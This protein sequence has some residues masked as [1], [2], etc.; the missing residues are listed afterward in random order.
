M[1]Q[2]FF[3][4]MEEDKQ[5]DR[6]VV[7]VLVTCG[8]TSDLVCVACKGIAEAVHNPALSLAM[9]GCIGV[10]S[11]V[12]AGLAL[13]QVAQLLEQKG[14]SE[15][16]LWCNGVRVLGIVGGV[17]CCA[18]S[19]GALLLVAAGASAI[20]VCGAGVARSLDLHRRYMQCH[21][22]L[23]ASTDAQIL[24]D[25]IWKNRAMM[26][27]EEALSLLD[28]FWQTQRDELLVP[29]E[30]LD[31]RIDADFALLDRVREALQK[32]TTQ[33]RIQAKKREIREKMKKS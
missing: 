26:S 18:C 22:E 31:S 23:L 11:G 4:G 15:R 12:S 28:S 21:C 14:N 24:V 20:L 5:S 32:L 13:E 27:C 8:V 3:F 10:L 16:L 33:E 6:S 29:L 7:Q 19:G 30:D 9:S 2:C 25:T 1:E 17:V